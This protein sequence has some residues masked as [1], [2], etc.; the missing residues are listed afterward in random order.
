MNTAQGC[1]RRVRPRQRPD[2]EPL[3]RCGG[4]EDAAKVIDSGGWQSEVEASTHPPTMC[5]IRIHASSQLLAM[6]FQAMTL[7]PGD[8]HPR[9]APPQQK[10]PR[11]QPLGRFIVLLPR[12]GPGHFQLN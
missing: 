4:F 2:F 3:L 6:C 10:K 8:D 11:A 12:R 1:R 7:N 5:Y 9:S